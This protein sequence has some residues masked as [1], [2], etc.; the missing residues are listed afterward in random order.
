MDGVEL[1]NII[2]Q[3]PYMSR[4]VHGILNFGQVAKIDTR[5]CFGTRAYI[6]YVSNHW[7]LLMFQPT[8]QIVYIDPLGKKPSA[9]SKI[10][11]DWLKASKHHVKSIPFQIQPNDSELCGLYILYFLFFLSR[12]V[13]FEKIVRKFHRKNMLLNDEMVSKFAVKKFNFKIKENL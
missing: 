7:L 1:Q 4:L 11:S 6:I 2:Q 13:Q 9:Y 5:R 8:G 10:L 3:D 12:G